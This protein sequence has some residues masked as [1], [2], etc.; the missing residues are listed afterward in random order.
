MGMVFFGICTG[1]AKIL[2]ILTAQAIDDVIDER[3]SVDL[4]G[5]LS[6]EL[7]VASRAHLER[8]FANSPVKVVASGGKVCEDE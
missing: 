1:L 5:Q 2:S 8:E 4:F 3:S 6:Q 7:N